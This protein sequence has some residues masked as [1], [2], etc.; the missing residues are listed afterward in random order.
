MPLGTY[1]RASRTELGLSP[2]EWDEL[3]TY[4][5]DVQSAFE[6]EQ[7]N[8]PAVERVEEEP[9]EIVDG[10]FC[11][12]GWVGHYPGDIIVTSDRLERGEERTM[13][14]DI[15]S[16]VE[17]IGS[18][19]FEAAFPVTPDLL[20]DRRAQLAAYSKVLID[21]TEIVRSN[22]LPVAVTRKQSRG[23]VPDGRPLM[24]QSMQLAAEGSQEIVTESVN[25]SFETL[26]NYLLV[27]FHADLAGQMRPLVESY[28]YYERGFGSQ[29]QYHETFLDEQLPKRLI[30]SAL[31]TNFSDPKILAQIRR[32][33]TGDIAEIVDLWEAF[34]HG[35]SLSLRLSKNLNTAV[36]PMSK[37]YEL[38]CLGLLIDILTEICGQPPEVDT[39]QGS[40]SFG[41]N[42]T[43][44][45]NRSLSRHS[46][47]LKPAFGVGARQS[48]DFA[49]EIDR[50]LVWIG[51]AKFKPW[52]KLNLSDYRRFLTYVLDFLSPGDTGS[53]L[54]VDSVKTHREQ[55]VRDFQIDHHSVR[56][57]RTEQARAKLLEMLNERLESAREA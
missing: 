35:Q 47:Y 45:Y 28:A 4:L 25:F 21:L 32:E 3:Q 43:L 7:A 53:I 26:T 36:K 5:L 20:L 56:P 27:R 22:R 24:A 8:L 46:N 50:K 16:W 2:E 13:L 49:L 39:I 14:R 18:R 51:D 38:W 33:A 15:Q 17:T 1:E 55:I 30:G 42:V 48:P 19:S 34:Q 31:E 11:P 37:V 41:N 54:Y 23:M 40:Y 10:K 44:Y 29:L 12:Y 6:E 57:N 52:G 9:P